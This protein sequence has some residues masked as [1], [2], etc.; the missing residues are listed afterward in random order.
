M[1]SFLRL[2]IYGFVV[3]FIHDLFRIG[4]F[5]GYTRK[6]SQTTISCRVHKIFLVLSGVWMHGRYIYQVSLCT[7]IRSFRSTSPVRAHFA[8]QLYVL[9]RICSI[10]VS[11][12][13]LRISKSCHIYSKSPE[14][15]PS[16]S[17]SFIPE[18]RDSECFPYLVFVQ[19]F[20]VENRTETAVKA[21]MRH[22]LMDLKTGQP[23][24]IFFFLLSRRSNRK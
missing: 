21:S 19:L 5:L 1:S 3:F 15:N 20:P 22:F 16:R 17:D 2:R 12:W 11:K 23:F 8:H 4:H 14:G 7:A 18:R 10:E 13:K 6:I 9:I 24:L